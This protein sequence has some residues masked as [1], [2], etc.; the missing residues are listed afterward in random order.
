MYWKCTA[1]L[2]GSDVDDGELFI[3][4]EDVYDFKIDFMDI[5]DTHHHTDMNVSLLD[6]ARPAKQK[7]K[8]K[9]MF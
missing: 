3:R 6:I 7:G 5:F 9:N 8:K 1:F 4:E 2:S